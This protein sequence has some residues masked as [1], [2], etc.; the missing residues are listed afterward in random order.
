M[1]FECYAKYTGFKK[2][3]LPDPHEDFDTVLE[4]RGLDGELYITERLLAFFDY[5]VAQSLA[6]SLANEDIMAVARQV[7]VRRVKGY[8]RRSV[9]VARRRPAGGA[10]GSSDSLLPTWREELKE[11]L[12]KYM[13]ETHAR[14]APASASGSHAA[15]QASDKSDVE[16]M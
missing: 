14:G 9:P 3:L 13:K 8:T 7:Y 15:A 4:R 16:D 10:G 5:N 11:V 12:T 1:W 6:Q 2:I